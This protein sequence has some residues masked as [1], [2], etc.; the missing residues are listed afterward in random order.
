MAAARR[1]G[2]VLLSLLVC[3]LVMIA[4]GGALFG[5]VIAAAIAERGGMVAV[6]KRKFE[7]LHDFALFRSKGDKAVVRWGQPPAKKRSK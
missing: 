4:V 5:P 1:R 6:S 7:A 3:L 2:G